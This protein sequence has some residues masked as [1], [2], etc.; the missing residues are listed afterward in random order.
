LLLIA[1][2]VFCMFSLRALFM[3]PTLVVAGIWPEVGSSAPSVS[4]ASVKPDAVPAFFSTLSGAS[5]ALVRVG[6][7]DPAQYTSSQDYN[8]W[9]YSTCSAAAMTE[10][11]NAYGHRYRL[12]DILKV[13]AGIGAISPDAGLLSPGGIDRTVARFNFSATGMKNPSLDDVMRVANHGHPVIVSF[14][15]QRW[16]GGHILV[17]IGG[18]NDYVYLADS[19]RLNMRAM[20]HPVFMKYWAG[21]A[22]V[23]TPR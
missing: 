20:S 22:V 12:A 1:L 13:E 2:F 17:V 8:V 23:V 11:I 9:A 18:N 10:V 14:P 21:F 4:A 7:L 19:S 15:P 3:S 16:A 6:Q 5:R